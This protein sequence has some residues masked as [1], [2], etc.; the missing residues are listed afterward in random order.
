MI[1]IYS[2]IIIRISLIF[3]VRGFSCKMWCNGNMFFTR[4]HLCLT[5]KI[6]KYHSTYTLNT[7]MKHIFVYY[8]KN[9]RS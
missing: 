1:D 8:M 5:N 7:S 3:L 2:L 6:S 9:V 4:W